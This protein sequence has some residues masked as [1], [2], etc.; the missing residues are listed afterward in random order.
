MIRRPPRSTLFPYTTLFRSRLDAVAE[1]NRA[2]IPCGILV[3]PLMPGVNDAPEQVEPLLEMA[4]D[5]G[6][7]SIGGIALHLRGEGRDIW[8]DWLRSNR[9]DLIPRYERLYARGAYAPAAGK[10]RMA[11][12]V[13]PAAG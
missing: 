10:E 13:N 7:V 1:L 8:V 9:P 6:A 5:A 4:A 3:A 2:G 11:R 12:L